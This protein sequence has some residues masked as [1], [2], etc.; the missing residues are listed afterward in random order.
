MYFAQGP[1]II[2][3]EKQQ[4]SHNEDAVEER[5]GRD[6]GEGRTARGSVQECEGCDQDKAL[7]G[8]GISTRAIGEKDQRAED[9]HVCQR[10]GVEGRGIEG[11]N[12]RRESTDE[13]IGGG[14]N[15]E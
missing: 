6:H 4:E 1:K 13:W 9:R 12:W 2:G 15:T 7:V 5:S 11:G 10:D 3:H 8:G 14:P